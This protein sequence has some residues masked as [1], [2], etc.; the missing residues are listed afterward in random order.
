M[1]KSKKIFQVK[2]QT[3][4]IFVYVSEFF[5]SSTQTNT[6]KLLNL[7]KV[8]C[9]DEHRI[10]LLADLEEA[11]QELQQKRQSESKCKRIERCIEKIKAQKWC[12]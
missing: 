4:Q 12:A 3:G 1:D 9:T 8:N 10:A 6:N 7:A 5:S 2:W 11:K